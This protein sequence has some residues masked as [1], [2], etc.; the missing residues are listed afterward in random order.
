MSL[1]HAKK[2]LEN[3]KTDKKLV[4]KIKAADDAGKKKIAA[5]MGLKFTGDEMKEAIKASSELSDENLETVSGGS[6]AN[7]MPVLPGAAGAAAS[8]GW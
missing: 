3:L 8:C 6:S 7:W 1:D 4:E 2:M 5:D